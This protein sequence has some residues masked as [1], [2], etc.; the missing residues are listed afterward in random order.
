MGLFTFNKLRIDRLVKNEA[1]IWK[2]ASQIVEKA[3]ETSA[4]NRRSRSPCPGRC[5][6]AAV[7]RVIRR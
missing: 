2:S 1:G 3:E 6:R 5:A 4:R 7:A